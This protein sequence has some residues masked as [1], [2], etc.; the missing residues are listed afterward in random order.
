M[1]TEK[2][3]ILVVLVPLLGLV[4]PQITGIQFINE[5]FDTLVGLVGLTT[6]FAQGIKQGFKYDSSEHWK[7][8]PYVIP[9][10]V[11]F[12]LTQAGYFLELGLFSDI[13]EWIEATAYTFLIWV[14]SMGWFDITLEKKKV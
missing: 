5:S 10:V 12:I 14:G 11:G 1:K 2:N 4:F 13:R 3:W 7:Y 8:W 6:I 9:L